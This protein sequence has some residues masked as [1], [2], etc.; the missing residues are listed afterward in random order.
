MF[1]CRSTVLQY[2]ESLRLLSE[3]ILKDMAKSLVLEEDCFLNEC[4]ERSNM[5]VRFNY[6]PSCPMPDDHVLDV[7]LHADGSTITFLKMKK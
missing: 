2:T 1:Q 5:I 7:K 6:Y 4:G 3:V